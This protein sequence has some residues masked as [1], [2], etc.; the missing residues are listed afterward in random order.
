MVR[1][2]TKG[3]GYMV[4]M[5]DLNEKQVVG[6]VSV[7]KGDE[8]FSVCSCASTIVRKICHESMLYGRNQRGFMVHLG[9][10]IRT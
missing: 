10:G 5:V 3:A 1:D 7:V 9:I 2:N 8:L 4:N 6:P